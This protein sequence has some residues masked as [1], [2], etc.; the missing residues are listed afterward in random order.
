[1]HLVGC[2]VIAAGS[3]PAPGPV[4]YLGLRPAKVFALFVCVRSAAIQSRASATLPRCRDIL[5]ACDPATLVFSFTTETFYRP[6]VPLAPVMALSA[7]C[8]VASRPLAA[9]VAGRSRMVVVKV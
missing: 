3:W 6:I 4:W 5:R 1:M 9:R 2:N 8:S 7:K